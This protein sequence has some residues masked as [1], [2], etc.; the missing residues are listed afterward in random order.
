MHKFAINF[1]IKQINKFLKKVMQE[2]NFIINDYVK[3]NNNK[4]SYWPRL[5]TEINNVTGGVDA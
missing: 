4:A 5:K 2:K 1:E 3:K